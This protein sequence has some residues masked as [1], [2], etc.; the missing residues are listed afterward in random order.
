MKSAISIKGLS[1]LY[2]LSRNP[3]LNISSSKPTNSVKALD[4]INLEIR[5]KECFGIVGKNGSGKSTLLQIICGT[6]KET[7]GEITKNGKIASILELGTSFN[8]EFTGKENI[9]LNCSLHGISR[10]QIKSMYPSIEAFAEIGDFIDLPVR[11]YSTGMSMRLAFAII[12]HIQADILIIDEALTV[13]DIYFTKKCIQFLINFKRKGT[14]ILV[15]HDLELLSYLC[16]RAALISNGSIIEVSTVK[17]ITSL[18]LKEFRNNYSSKSDINQKILQQKKINIKSDTEVPKRVINIF[19][20]EK[21]IDLFQEKKKSIIDIKNNKNKTFTR[22][23][24]KLLL[25]ID[26]RYSNQDKIIGINLYNKKGL[27]II[28][29]IIPIYSIHNHA[30]PTIEYNINFVIPQLVGGEYSL[31]IGLALGNL[32]NHKFIQLIHDY[33]RW[34]VPN[35]E[36][37]FGLINTPCSCTQIVS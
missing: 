19:P 11:T 24:I 36:G 4:R 2:P 29:E 1:K 14:L 27:L 16:D 5:K 26:S 10:Q 28:S 35:R 33:E 9:F 22:E 18:Y 30:K 12:T 17:E 20:G 34:Y 6:L 31:D 32:I 37:D 8:P 25:I 13:G 15:T 7:S 3:I 23:T 21:K